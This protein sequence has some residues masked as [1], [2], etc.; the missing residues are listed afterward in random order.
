M[1]R[2]VSCMGRHSKLLQNEGMTDFERFTA[3]IKISSFMIFGGVTHTAGGKYFTAS[4]QTI[5]PCFFL[6][7]DTSN[8]V[9]TT[10]GR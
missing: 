5:Q 9:A 3:D 4:T 1:V 2:A 7:L 8:Q 6:P 10:V